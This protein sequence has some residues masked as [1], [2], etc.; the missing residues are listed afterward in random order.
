MGSLAQTLSIDVTKASVTQPIS[1]LHRNKYLELE[2]EVVLSV[3]FFVAVSVVAVSML[4][5]KAMFLTVVLL[6]ITDVFVVVQNR[7]GVHGVVLLA[8]SCQ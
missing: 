5:I 4:A 3:V 6:Q 8:R 7:L 2:N 1:Q